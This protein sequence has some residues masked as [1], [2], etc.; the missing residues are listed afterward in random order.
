[1][2]EVGKSM[3]G[4]V[5]HMFK[6]WRSFMSKE[7]SNLRIVIR[8]VALFFFSIA[9]FFGT[10]GT[11]RWVEAWVYLFVFFSTYIP[12]V[13]WMKKNDPEL[14]KDRMGFGKKKPKGGDIL[15]LLMHEIFI[16]ALIVLPGLD[17]VRFQ[18]SKVPLII[19]VL[20]IFMI[21]FA[22]IISFLVIKENPYLSWIVEV[23]EDKGQ[24]VISTG[25]YAHVRHPWYSA[26]FLMFLSIP[27]A[28]GSLYSLIPALLLMMN[29]IVRIFIEE[30]SMGKD[31]LDYKEYCQKVK[32]RVCP[33]IW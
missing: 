7:V 5:K 24:K 4:V 15:V 31:L 29:I 2:E 6:H 10:A 25:I 20:G 18:W 17:A 28:L 14:L 12:T 33:Y 1:V 16:T 11:L 8:L 30:K 21:I 13:I 26:L 3:P 32:Y 19:K 23:R 9:V 22:N 27:L